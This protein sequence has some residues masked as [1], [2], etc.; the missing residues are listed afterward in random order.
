MIGAHRSILQVL[1]RTLY[2]Q[3]GA[4]PGPVSIFDSSKSRPTRNIFFRI[5]SGAPSL[6]SGVVATRSEKSPD[7]QRLPHTRFPRFIATVVRTFG[8]GR[9]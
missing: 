1:H 9:S 3:I 6:R 5:L 4:R 2:D 7:V 8:K